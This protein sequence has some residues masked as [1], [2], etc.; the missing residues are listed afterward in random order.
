MDKAWYLGIYGQKH[1]GPEYKS[2][3]HRIS[4]NSYQINFAV[5]ID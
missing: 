3:Y 2:N 5:Q 1:Q 4:N